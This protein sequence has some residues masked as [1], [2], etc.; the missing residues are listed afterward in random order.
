MQSQ[1]VVDLSA[2]VDEPMGQAQGSSRRA[3][4]EIEGEEGGGPGDQGQGG[5]GQ[6]PEGAWEED[7]GGEEDQMGDE[8]LSQDLLQPADDDEEEYLDCM[9][10]DAE[11]QEG[12][13][14]S[15]GS[16]DYLDPFSEVE[17]WEV[18]WALG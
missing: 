2:D 15:Q 1:D 7:E 4:Q 3:G 17:D 18:R 10:E 16:G 5:E 6:G 14:G 11:V 8:Q 13:G 12:E 9:E